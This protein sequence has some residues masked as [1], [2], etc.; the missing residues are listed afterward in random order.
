[1]NVFVS[2]TTGEAPIALALKDLLERTFPGSVT[3][4][5]SSDVH[6]LTPGDK[7]LR[8]IEAALKQSNLVLVICSPSSLTRPWINFEAGC[9]WAQGLDIIPICHSG[10]KKDQLPHPFS[11]LQALQLEDE[12][13]GRS[14]ISV[15]CQHLKVLNRGPDVDLGKV[16]RKL[17]KATRATGASE[18]LPLIINCPRERTK[19]INDDLKLILGTPR[20]AQETVWTS[21][22]LSTFAIGPDDPYP[23]EDKD[24]LRL[25]LQEREMLMRLAGKGCT[26]K[27]IISPANRNHI[28][29]AGIDYAVKRT[30][31]LLGLLRSSEKAL[32]SIDWAISEL[33]VKNLY[34]LGHVSCFEGYKKGVHQGY[35]LTLRQTAPDVISANISLHSGFFRDLA[36]RTLLK[37]GRNTDQGGERELLRNAAIRC[38]EDSLDFLTEFA[39][40]TPSSSA[41]QAEAVPPRGR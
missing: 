21:A 16:H 8:K 34:I 27:C 30:N 25:L 15:F 24:L 41:A 18:A 2:H 36:A 10:Q 9:A 7:W 6:D 3:V 38:L 23:P 39:K 22:F 20:V 13:F 14:L 19:L 28:R 33:G 12:T 40:A 11:E 26:I 29:H 17:E 37:W 32:K 5:V 35:G 31:R 1:M 4:F